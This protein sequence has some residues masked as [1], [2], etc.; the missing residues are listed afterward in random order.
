MIN[1][2][3]D[4]SQLR[5]VIDSMTIAPLRGLARQYGIVPGNKK[6][7]ELEKEIFDVYFGK[8]KP[9]NRIKIGRPSKQFGDTLPNNVVSSAPFDT[10][11]IVE[12]NKP[13]IK[14][15]I[16]EGILEI[17]PE[18]YGFLRTDNYQ[19]KQG[20]DI[21]VAP[22]QI[23]KYSLR[24][25][26]KIV[27]S[28]KYDAN[29]LSLV[30]IS[31]VNDIIDAYQY[32]REVFEELEQSNP[33][34]RLTLEHARTEFSLRVMDLITPIGRGQRG[35]IVAPNNAGKTTLLK[36][37][38]QA[39]SINHPDVHLVAVL[40]DD[41]VEEIADFADGLDCE[42]V[43]TTFDQSP[44]VHMQVVDLVI[45]NAK[46]RVEQ[47]Q[48][49]VVLIDG[50]TRLAR[51]YQQLAL[52]SDKEVEVADIVALQ[53]LKM[54]FGAGRNIK[55]GGSLTILATAS[56]GGTTVD[57]NIV[58]MLTDCANMLVYLDKG[59]HDSLIFPFINI[60]KSCTR[61]DDMLLTQEQYEAAYFVRNVVASADSDNATKELLDMFTCT[62]NNK[63]FIDCLKAIVAKK[64]TEDNN[65]DQDI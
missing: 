9:Q 57:D 45:K 15:T 55:E 7:A 40:V 25:G 39:V 64:D 59:M 5:A 14:Q 3:K 13:T 51:I 54:L 28:V 52:N 32:Q 16:V 6:R 23:K 42:V 38:A 12:D 27:G 17:M 61:R 56:T 8:I 34:Q 36:K 1:D 18:N 41:S 22:A 46:R 44:L 35:L 50:I 58:G 2:I 19:C 53:E 31:K 30:Q 63:E 47:E 49:V 60:D 33:T 21:Y 11:E 20:K 62:N 29:T 24:T 10:T 37:I 65:S 4:F 26:D 43:Y 48:H